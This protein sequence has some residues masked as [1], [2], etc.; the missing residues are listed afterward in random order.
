MECG[1]AWRGAGFWKSN[2]SNGTVVG[3]WSM[4][5]RCRKP[6]ASPDRQPLP[7]VAR[8]GDLKTTGGCA[9]SAASCDVL[10]DAVTE[11]PVKGL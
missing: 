3:N 11:P 2:L 10:V 1:A 8:R 4:A 6:R 7:A 9:R 5:G